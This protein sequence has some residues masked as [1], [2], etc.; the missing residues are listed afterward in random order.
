[1]EWAFGETARGLPP[2]ST[3]RERWLQWVLPAVGH[4]FHVDVSVPF[5][6][7]PEGWVGKR[8]LCSGEPH[9]LGSTLIP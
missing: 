3:D 7:S 5:R 8:V 2:K 4:T 9:V 1:M 6:L